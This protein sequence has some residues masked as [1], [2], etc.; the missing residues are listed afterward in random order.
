MIETTL[1]KGKISITGLKIKGK[2]ADEIILMP[3]ESF[4]YFKNEQVTNI[5][6][7]KE[8]KYLTPTASANKTMPVA[9]TTP[10]AIVV[11]NVNVE[12]IIGWKEGKLFFDNETFE[13]LSSKFERRY[14]VKIY[15]EDKRVANLKYTGVFEKENINQALD[16]L[17]LTTPFE[18]KMNLKDIYISYKK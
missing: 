6:L 3:K 7:K 16:A 9:P 5:D 12:P 1:V 14:D 2:K 4:K 17:K 18:Y 11:Q 15:F 13:S 10:K 8:M